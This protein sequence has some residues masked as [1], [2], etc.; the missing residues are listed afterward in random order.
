MTKP[1]NMTPEE[2]AAWRKRISERQNTPEFKTKQRIRN[3]R[4]YA[5]PGSKDR[6]VAKT[7][8]IRS[9]LEGRERRNERERALATKP[10]NLKKAAERKTKWK[11]SE[12]G[13]KLY[14]AQVERYWHRSKTDAEFEAFMSSMEGADA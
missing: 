4:F 12:R 3:H 5:K 14:R 13:Q 1:K 8:L 7:K 10:E 2:D 6:I 11:S 9:T